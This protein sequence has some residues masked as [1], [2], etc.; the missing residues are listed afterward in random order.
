MNEPDR[1]G[2]AR[3][4]R[5]DRSASARGLAAT[6]ADPVDDDV[7]E[8][9]SGRDRTDDRISLPTDTPT[10]RPPMHAVTSPRRED[11]SFI[12]PDGVAPPGSRHGTFYARHG[13]RVLDLLLGGVALVVALPVLGVAALAVRLTMGGPVLFRQERIGLDGRPITVLKLRTMKPDRRRARSRK[14]TYSGPERRQTHKTPQHPLLT[15]V[16]KFLRK[17]SI[18]ELPQIFNVLRG[19]MTIVGPRP[20]LALVVERYEPWECARM[21]VRPGLTGLWQITARGDG[22]LMHERVD[23][24]IDYLSQISLRTDLRIIARTPG[25]MLGDHKGV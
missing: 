21:L 9:G 8:Q 13:K 1:H 5:L 24:D 4:R 16:G 22:G 7:D 12:I 25:A 11:G 17:Y 15:P 23:L 20:E 2:T 10:E 18:D 6:S 19:D 3:R 14:N